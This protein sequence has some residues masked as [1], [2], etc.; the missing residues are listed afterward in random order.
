ME[1][2]DQSEAKNRLSKEPGI[3]YIPSRIA[4]ERASREDNG[5]NI[6]GSTTLGRKGKRA[7]G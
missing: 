5:R 1:G 6:I 7:M 3:F 2:Q 4:A